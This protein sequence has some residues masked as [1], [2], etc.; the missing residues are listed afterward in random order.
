VQPEQAAKE[1][2]RG[3]NRPDNG[4]D[5]RWAGQRTEAPGHTRRGMG[6]SP[7]RGH[8]TPHGRSVTE[9]RLTGHLAAE[10]R[11]WQKAEEPLRAR[12]PGH[13]GRAKGLWFGMR[14]NE[15]DERG[16]A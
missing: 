14:H 1:L 11:P 7:Y 16:V 9:A 13:A 4:E 2:T 3:S 10:D 8:T 12:K 6:R 5:Q 15:T